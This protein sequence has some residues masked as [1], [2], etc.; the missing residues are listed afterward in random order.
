MIIGNKGGL[1][2]ETSISRV[3]LSSLSRP[4]SV[5]TSTIRNRSNHIPVWQPGRN[6]KSRSYQEMAFCLLES[7]DYSK[8]KRTHLDPLRRGIVEREALKSI[9]I[10]FKRW[11]RSKT[12][13]FALVFSKENLWEKYYSLYTRIINLVLAVCLQPI[14]AAT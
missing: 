2:Y 7:F 8:I 6:I 14:G 13:L 5:E 9:S 11:M 4:H 12:R 10:L 1:N 3:L